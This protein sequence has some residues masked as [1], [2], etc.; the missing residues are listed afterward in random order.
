VLF[1]YKG[2]SGIVSLLALEV[3]EEKAFKK[4]PDLRNEADFPV[5][6]RFV[7]FTKPTAAMS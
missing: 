1:Y 5:C 4:V 7:N 2:Y 3:L 6:R